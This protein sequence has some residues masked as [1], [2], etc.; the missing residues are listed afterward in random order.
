MSTAKTVM[1]DN[2]IKILV[3]VVSIP[4]IISSINV[5]IIVIAILKTNVRPN[6]TRNGI[7]SGL[8]YNTCVNAYPGITKII[9]KPRITRKSTNTKLKK[10]RPFILLFSSIDHTR[11]KKFLKIYY[12]N[13]K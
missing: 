13:K 8:G 3:P 9:S 5:E 10:S 12:E 2:I 1:I 11:I 7:S 6:L 4:R